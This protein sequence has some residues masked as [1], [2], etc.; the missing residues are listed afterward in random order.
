MMTCVK[1]A[2]DLATARWTKKKRALT[3]AG[4]LT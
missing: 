1:D 2:A 4:R 3:D